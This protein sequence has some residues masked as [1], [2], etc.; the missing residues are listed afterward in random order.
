[1]VLLGPVVVGCG[2]NGFI[3]EG[4]IKPMHLCWHTANCSLQK[5]AVQLQ[6]HHTWPNGDN[7]LPRAIICCTP[8]TFEY[9]TLTA[10][11][12]EVSHLGART[13]W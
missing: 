8:I 10:P 6:L 5:T 3:S 11:I 2:V 9:N 13:W 1:L 4:S 12:L 7:S